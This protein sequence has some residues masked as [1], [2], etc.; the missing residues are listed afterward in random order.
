MIIKLFKDV[1]GN[2]EIDKY[3]K[4]K[5]VPKLK[6][7]LEGLGYEVEDIADFLPSFNKNLPFIDKP[8][9]MKRMTREI[10]WLNPNVI[11]L[12]LN[13]KKTNELI[14]KDVVKESNM[15]N[16]ENSKVTEL[17]VIMQRG[18]IFKEYEK[19]KI[20][21]NK[22]ENN[23]NRDALQTDFSKIYVEQQKLL[24]QK[25]LPIGTKVFIQ[26]KDLH[27]KILNYNEKRG[28]YDV[29]DEK[30]YKCYHKRKDLLLDSQKKGISIEQG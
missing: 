1:K 12:V 24:K 10:D 21:N 16:I 23:E 30:G 19:W 17:A 15:I 11:F 29:E 14:L 6:E 4:E 3:F 18:Y 27:G 22:M 13:S 9:I 28:E 2:V 26:S 7:F 8:R 20:E 25:R 5:D